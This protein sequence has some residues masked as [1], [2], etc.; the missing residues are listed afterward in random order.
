MAEESYVTVRRWD[1]ANLWKSK[2]PLLN[3]MDVELTERC[4]NN[5]SHCFIN[6]PA[7]HRCREEELSFQ[8]IKSILKEAARL[9]CMS[10]R[11]TGGEPLLREDFQ[12][13]YLFARSLGLRVLIFTNATLITPKFVEILSRVPPLET[14]EVTVYGMTKESYE[15]VTRNPGS[16]EAAFEGMRLLL[17]HRVPFVVKGAVLPWNKQDMEEFEAWAA[18]TIPSMDKTPSYALFFDLRCRK[19][20]EKNSLIERI[21]IS[22]EEGVKILVRREGYLQEMKVFCSKFMSPPGDKLFSCGSGLGQCSMDP[23]GHL[24]PCLLLK[25]P[26]TSYDLKRGSLNDALANTFPRLRDMKASNPEYLNRCALCFLKG[27]CEQCPA[28]SWLEHGSLDTPV[29][30]LCRIAHLQAKH[31]GLLED[32]EMAWEVKNWKERVARLAQSHNT[33]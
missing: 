12:E 17:E 7:N 18:S 30:Y 32:G 3:R 2:S 23:Y 10:V 4:N 29:E 20:P 25:D 28:K 21:R 14:M 26:D 27:L 8:E 31:L 9:G 5:C 1:K 6:L 24:Q 22:A 15:A 11:F 13:I 19:E 16:F 33:R